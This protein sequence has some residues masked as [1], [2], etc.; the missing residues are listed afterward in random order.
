MIFGIVATIVTFLVIAVAMGRQTKRNKRAAIEDLE[1]EKK[2]LAQTNIFTL[3]ID[4]IEDLGLRSITGA[5]ELQPAVLLKTWKDNS[6]VAEQCSDRAHLRFVVS[7][8]VAP[9][10]AT[11]NDV[12]LICESAPDPVKTDADPADD[13]GDD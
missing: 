11:G 10:V 13:E 2:Q 8:G 9:D 1:R 4:E 3:M 7:D 12:T 5:A 6:D